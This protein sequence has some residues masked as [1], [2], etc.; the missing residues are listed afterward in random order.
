[1]QENSHALCLAAEHHL[2]ARRRY[3]HCAQFDERNHASRG[4]IDAKRVGRLEVVH[5]VRGDE[6]VPLLRVTVLLDLLDLARKHG[7]LQTGGHM[8]IIIL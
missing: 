8:E 3:D 6:E 7:R 2:L 5:G 4:G 1:M